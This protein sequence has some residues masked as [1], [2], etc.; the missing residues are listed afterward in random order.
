MTAVSRK[1]LVLLILT[2]LMLSTSIQPSWSSEWSEGWKRIEHPDA[3]GQYLLAAPWEWGRT[4][5]TGA[6]AEHEELEAIKPR[7]STIEE[8]MAEVI[9][10]LN[11]SNKQ[12]EAKTSSLAGILERFQA[13]RRARSPHRSRARHL[14]CRLDGRR[15]YYGTGYR[16]LEFTVP[17]E[18]PR[19]GGSTASYRDVPV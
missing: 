12:I 7:M 17:V 8:Q 6:M 10:Y 2:F 14:D 16:H 9:E 1:L 15:F 11:E 3:P 18:R 5:L 19:N 4:V 13:W